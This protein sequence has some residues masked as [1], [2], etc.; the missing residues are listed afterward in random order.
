MWKQRQQLWCDSIKRG[1]VKIVFQNS[2]DKKNP[3]TTTTK[4]D[5]NKISYG[6]FNKVF[7]FP[8]IFYCIPIYN[9]EFL[10]WNFSSSSSFFLFTRHRFSISVCLFRTFSLAL[11]MLLLFKSS[12]IYSVFHFL[13]LVCC[14][15]C[16]N[17]SVHQITFLQ[18][19][20][21]KYS[22]LN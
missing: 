13:R 4:N 16:K 12:N 22:F 8:C 5:Y 1:S 9:S 14:W 10:F 15:C 2:L 18:E 17:I 21:K 6:T 3:T 19:Q 7:F 20:Q 11:L